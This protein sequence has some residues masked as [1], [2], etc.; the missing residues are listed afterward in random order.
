M[1]LLRTGRL[2]APS[3]RAQPR[4]GPSPLHGVY[5]PVARNSLECL[6]AA[7]RKT[8]S[9]ASHQVFDSSRH[10]HLASPG[11]R[12]HSGTDVNGNATDARLRPPQ[13]LRPCGLLSSLSHC[14]CACHFPLKEIDISIFI[15]ALYSLVAIK[16]ARDPI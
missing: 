3:S 2:S 8:Q 7:I 9:G 14:G 6:A 12:S 11:Q 16:L 1:I 15:V 13:K 10:Q 4:I 5:L